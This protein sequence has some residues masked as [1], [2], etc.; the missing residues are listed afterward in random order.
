M[1]LGII[2][3]ARRRVSLI[4]ILRKNIWLT[5]FFVYCGLSLLWSDFPEIASK[6]WIKAFGDP[7]MV[8]VVLTEAHP[9]Q[10]LAILLKRIAYLLLPM[11]VVF[12]KYFPELG[13]DYDPWTGWAFYTG[14]TTNKNMLGYLLFVFGLLF[15]VRSSENSAATAKAAARLRQELPSFSSASSGGCS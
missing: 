3:L 4:E 8:L 6:R 13:K 14:V 11:S 7:I 10:A 9:T 5:I 15:R 1:I 12:I 2:V